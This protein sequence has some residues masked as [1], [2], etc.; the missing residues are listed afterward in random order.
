MFYTKSMLQR[1]REYFQNY[2]R[3]RYGID[4]LGKAL[5]IPAIIVLIMTMFTDG[6]VHVILVFLGWAL[7]FLMYFRMF[8]KNILKRGAENNWYKSKMNYLKMRITQ[9]KDYKFFDC[10]NCKA[11]LRVPRGVGKI[12]ITCSKCGTRFDRK[13]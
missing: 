13:A 2:M 3:G 12:T 5:S 7:I 10:P 9:A 1:I 11:H 6:I 8:S 4:E